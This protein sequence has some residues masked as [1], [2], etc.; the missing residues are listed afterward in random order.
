MYLRGSNFFWDKTEN[1]EKRDV[2]ELIHKRI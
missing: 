1:V 2:L